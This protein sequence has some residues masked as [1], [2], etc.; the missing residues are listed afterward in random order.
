MCICG[1]W[2]L[3]NMNTP[4]DQIKR[5]TD[6]G[7]AMK[8]FLPEPAKTLEVGGMSRTG[9]GKIASINFGGDS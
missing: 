1:S 3:N 8:G 4:F 7:A 2:G 6:Y 9:T 5:V